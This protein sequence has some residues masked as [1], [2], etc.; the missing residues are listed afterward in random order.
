MERYAESRET[1]I[2][3]KLRLPDGRVFVTSSL[4]GKIKN[5]QNIRLRKVARS[6]YHDT[7]VKD[8]KRARHERM[9]KS[10]IRD[11]MEEYNVNERQAWFKIKYSHQALGL[12]MPC[13][14]NFE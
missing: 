8:S 14:S 1:H 7:I 6:Y 12:P 11:V 2:P 4:L 9:V 13:K 3:E 10:R 5:F